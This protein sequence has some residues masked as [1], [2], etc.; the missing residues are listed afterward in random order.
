GVAQG[1][2]LG[3]LLFIIYVNDILT[4]IDGNNGNLNVIQYADD[5][6]FL[7]NAKALN[8][9]ESNANVLVNRLSI[10]CKI[11]RMLINV[12]KTHCISFGFHSSNLRLPDIYYNNN[13]LIYLD[14]IKILGVWFDQ[15]LTFSKHVSEIR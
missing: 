11:N 12:E 10:R 2:I 7:S 8:D 15:R 5:T 4:C 14:A 1:S 13:N 9:V 6:T 3:P